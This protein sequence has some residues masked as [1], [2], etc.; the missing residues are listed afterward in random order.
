[1]RSGDP[2]LESQEIVAVS[3]NLSRGTEQVQQW[4]TDHPRWSF[5]FTPTHASW[6]NQVDVVFS[7]LYRRLLKHGLFTSEQGLPQPLAFIETYNLTVEPFK[8]MY[9]GKLLEARV[10]ELTG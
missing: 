5:Q 4:L 9:T 2:A 8:C 6:L 1:V 7:I 10:D 3:D